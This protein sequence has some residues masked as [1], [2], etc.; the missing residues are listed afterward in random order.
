MLKIIRRLDGGGIRGIWT[1]F[2]IETLMDYV[3]DEEMK[4][5]KPAEHSFDP[6][7]FPKYVSHG[8]FLSHEDKNDHESWMNSRKFLPCH[9]FDIV[10]GSSTGAKIFGNP[11]HVTSLSVGL[12]DRTKYDHKI[13]EK[14]FKDVAKRRERK[15]S[16][17]SNNEPLFQTGKDL[18]GTFVTS[19]RHV[20]LEAGNEKKPTILRSYDNTYRDNAPYSQFEMNRSTPCPGARSRA[21]V[22]DHGIQRILRRRT[23][24]FKLSGEAHKWPVW[25]VARAATA[26]D[27]YFEPLQTEAQG[28]RGNVTYTDGGLDQR[29]NPTMEAVWETKDLY[30]PSSLGAVV[31]V[32][33]A[34]GQTE[35]R[36]AVVRKLKSMIADKTDPES[37]H[38]QAEK[39]I[40]TNRY[41]RLNEPGALDI[42]LDDWRPRKRCFWKPKEDSGS[43]TLRYMRTKFN[44][45]AKDPIQAGKFRVCAEELVKRRRARTMDAAKWE[46]FATGIQFHCYADRC[47][48]TFLDRDEL[49]NHVRARHPSWQ[50]LPEEAKA[51][52][53]RFASFWRYQDGDR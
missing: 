48:T 22:T 39:E 1:L 10:C 5:S 13:I 25:M 53:M 50:R 11:R 16:H 27:F 28:Y 51:Q 35:A 33:T 44:N 8:P 17:D 14:I 43:Q 49:E 18:C 30:G 24:S 31:S 21:D 20:P 7:P 6:V 52:A 19:I 2:A 40:Q 37:V 12:I 41:F 3:A 23:A 4:Q 15:L 29:N 42:E 34:R 45:W 36:V 47:R 32:G 38:R 46:H 9:Y 26:A